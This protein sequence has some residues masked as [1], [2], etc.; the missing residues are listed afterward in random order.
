[1]QRPPTRVLLVPLLSKEP[2]SNESP[3]WSEQPARALA[4]FYRNRFNA[5]V[6]Q[7]R[8]VWS[9]ADYYRQV[10]QIQQ[11]LSYFDRVIFISHGGFDGPVLNN[12]VFSQDFKITNGKAKLLQLS[13]SQPG[14][15][16]T[17]SITYEPEKNRLFSDY[18]A[19]RWGELEE[20]AP[21]II[22]RRLKDLEK[23][24][25][26]LDQ[27]C[28]QQYC[29]PNQLAT[30]PIQQH[31]YRLQ[32]C[33]QICR[34]PL[35]EQKVSAAIS[36]ERF[37]HF[38]ESLSSLT[39]ED[40]LIFF[41]ACNP[42]SAAPVKTV[43]KDETGL[44]INS[45]LAGGPHSSYV[46]LISAATGRITAGPIGNSSAEDIVNRI[47]MFENGRSQQYLCIAA[48]TAN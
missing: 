4:A 5:S 6:T 32:L 7:F 2:H 8:D 38:A 30:S 13:E 22:W 44:L 36:P 45:P 10:E 37:L 16:N 18:M 42:G 26:P 23:Q 39:T 40:G 24:I 9:W 34:E 25:Q 47:V 17:L 31:S 15:K 43:E 14:L 28:F 21:S 35:F 33:E 27:A 48:P 11:E 3:R 19:T 20:L 29:S 12:A 41:G 1:M 46:H